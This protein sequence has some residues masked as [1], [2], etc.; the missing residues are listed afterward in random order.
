MM[1][2][3]LHF[4]ELE[5]RRKKEEDLRKALLS[6]KTERTQIEEKYATLQEIAAVKSAEAGRLKKHLQDLKGELHELREVTTFV[7]D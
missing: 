2:G 6:K 7:V 1:I 3:S 4:R 5:A